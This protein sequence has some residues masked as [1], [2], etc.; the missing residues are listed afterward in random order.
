MN[1]LLGCD[2]FIW[3]LANIFACWIHRIVIEFQKLYSV[4]QDTGLKRCR[5]M[6]YPYGDRCTFLASALRFVVD[7]ALWDI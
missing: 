1:V 6:M 7:K 4:I 2:S 5:L 3:I